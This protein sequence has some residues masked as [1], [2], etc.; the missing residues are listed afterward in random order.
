MRMIAER[1]SDVREYSDAELLSLIAKAQDE[2]A[3]THN[4]PATRQ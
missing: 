3:R 1:G 2:Q 4:G